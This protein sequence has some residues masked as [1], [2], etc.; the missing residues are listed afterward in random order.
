MAAEHDTIWTVAKGHTNKPG[1][2]LQSRLACRL[3]VALDSILGAFPA[4]AFKR[5]VINH[6]IVK[7]HC[8]SA[9]WLLLG[10]DLFR[11]LIVGNLR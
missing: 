7:A 10:K 3:S 11:S 9:P 5:S 4:R 8:L 6:S 1:V 2:Y